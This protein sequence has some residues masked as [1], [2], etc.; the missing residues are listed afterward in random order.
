MKPAEER[1]ALGLTK[2]EQNILR[3]IQ[4]AAAELNRQLEI[5]GQSGLLWLVVR[6][7]T[8]R[9]LGR[10]PVAGEQ[11]FYDEPRQWD[12]IRVETNQAYPLRRDPSLAKDEWRG[13]WGTP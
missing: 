3:G 1:R 11:P 7:E 6:T 4:R 9:D 12:H 10:N 13:G 8:I 2:H 5:A